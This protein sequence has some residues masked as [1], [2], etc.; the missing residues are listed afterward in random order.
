MGIEKNTEKELE[1]FK[2]LLYI[3]LLKIRTFDTAAEVLGLL[4]T[5][6]TPKLIVKFRKLA[7]YSGKYFRVK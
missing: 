4:E 7:T 3:R 5:N 1:V 6:T 2:L